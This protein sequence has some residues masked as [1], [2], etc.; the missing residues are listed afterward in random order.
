MNAIVSPLN[1]VHLICEMADEWTV[2][3]GGKKGGSSKPPAAKHA[4]HPPPQPRMNHPSDEAADRER[5]SRLHQ[6]INEMRVKLSSSLVYQSL[7]SALDNAGNLQGCNI[8]VGEMVIYG[9]GSMEDSLTSRW[10]LALALALPGL[11]TLNSLSTAAAHDKLDS[12]LQI[13]AFDPA[14]GPCDLLLMKSLGIQVIQENEECRRFASRPTFFYMPHCEGYLY[15][16]LVTHN[17]SHG[18]LANVIILGNSFSRYGESLN[19]T[20]PPKIMDLVARGLVNE[21]EVPCDQPSRSRSRARDEGSIYPEG[22]FNN[23]SLHM[24]TTPSSSSDLW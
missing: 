18:L 15:E 13:Y 14:F 19:G 7:Q 12:S 4:T 11:L 8:Q 23:T 16:S 5:A 2:V 1:L 22:A 3:K 6:T 20:K 10:Q 24:F 9:L 21:I 17:L